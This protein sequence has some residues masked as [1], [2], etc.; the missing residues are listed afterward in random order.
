MLFS[1]LIFIYAFLPLVCILY[2][3][4][5]G[6]KVKN[7]IL[8][9]ASVFFYGFGE[10]SFVYVMLGS[11]LLNYV[12][13]LLVDSFRGQAMAKIAMVLAVVLNIGLLF[14]YKYLGYT[15]FLLSHIFPIQVLRIVLPIGISFFTFQALSYVID[16]YRGDAQVQKNPL[17]LALFIAFFPQ[18]IA[19]PIV[20]YNTIDLAIRER[21]HSLWDI[22]KGF[23]RFLVG[24]FKKVLLA[25]N[26]A[27]IADVAFGNT[28]HI[29]MAMA[30]LGLIAYA[31]QIFFDFAGYSDMAIGL[32]R[33]F[34]FHL[35]EN[36]DYPYISKSVS[37]FWRRWHI[38]LGIWF[39]D[40]VY[41]PLGGS[42][43]GLKRT[44]LN[45]FI[46]WS[47]TGIWHGANLTF[48][49]WGLYYFVLIALEKLT[50]Y[51][52]KLK[53]KSAKAL[54]QMGAMFFVLLGWV[55]FR[56]ETL[57]VAG[58]YY[59]ALFRLDGLFGQREFALVQG[60]GIFLLAGLLFCTPVA[61]WLSQK[62]SGSR[63]ENLVLFLRAGLYILLFIITTATLVMGS[64]NPFIY[65]QF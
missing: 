31:M 28:Q 48:A 32:A 39:R 35:E 20:R 60:Y 12:F 13:G 53:R 38:S 6:P 54:F 52:Q 21:K 47:L 40:Y 46:V 23:E 18:L 4:P 17:D 24:L 34:G 58:L 3:I 64:H 11:I 50:G 55:I 37:E 36:F 10:P 57:D 51:P 65:F 9:V 43:K 62:I 25:N 61:K 15:S 45:L 59:A 8:T 16:V 2:Y 1:S 49:I 14:V 63:L 19:G 44:I 26:F 22:A 33:M 41:F 30:W 56:A 42:R 7:F 5:S 29:S 27:L